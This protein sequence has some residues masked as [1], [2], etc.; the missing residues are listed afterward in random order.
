MEKIEY[1]PPTRETTVG[2]PAGKRIWR[3]SRGVVRE[4]DDVESLP[5]GFRASIE[6]SDEDED[7]SGGVDEK[8]CGER[9]AGEWLCLG[10]RWR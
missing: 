9:G 1:F 2:R 4:R 6:E 7:H 3:V 8:D 10:Y 5:I